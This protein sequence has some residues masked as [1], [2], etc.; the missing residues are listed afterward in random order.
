GRWSFMADP[1]WISVLWMLYVLLTSMLFHVE[2]RYRLPIYPALLPYA[3]WAIARIVDFRRQ[4]TRD[5]RHATSTARSR[6]GSHISR[7]VSR[8]ARPPG[9][10]VSV[11]IGAALTCLAIVYMTLQHRPYV[12]EAWM[13]ARKHVVLWQANRALAGGDAVRARALAEQALAIDPDSA[14][15][16]V[17]LARAAL[18]RGDQAAALGALD[19]AIAALPAHPHAHLLRGALLREQGDR[20][21][22]RAELSYEQAS[23]E[24]LQ[25]WSWQTFAP[26]ATLPSAIDIGSGLDLGYVRG[27]W[28]AVP[29]GGARWS[30]G[31]AEVML[32]LPEGADVRLELRLNSG[33]P[34]GA[35]APRVQI[36]VGGREIGQLVAEAGR[37]RYDFAIP[38][39]LIP[40]TRRLVVGIRSPTFRPRDFDRASPDNRA[41]G[42]MVERVEVKVP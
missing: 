26:F 3:A 41:L 25:E 4:A 28:P 27:F 39:E 7:L 5:R 23:L 21:A 15:A 24:D 6:L 36:V 22:A 31:E 16:R 42:V 11:L 40:D 19:Q 18:V 37:H 9:H 2:L 10:L 29:P 17:G 12:G 8:V 13:L 35:P 38:A 14:L 33:R 34:A 20:T 32:G 30:Q 1:R